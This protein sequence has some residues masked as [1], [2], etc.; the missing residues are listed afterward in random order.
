[1]HPVTP[2]GLLS[3]FN[4]NDLTPTE[5]LTLQNIANGSYFVEGEVPTGLINGNNRV[6]T[7][8]HTVNPTSS[9]EVY[10]GGQLMQSGGGDYTFSSTNTITFITAPPTGSIL[11]VNY[12]RQP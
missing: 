1:M 9:I 10:L 7:T 8:A 6:Y 3:P 12:R 2:G 4:G 11:L 5:E